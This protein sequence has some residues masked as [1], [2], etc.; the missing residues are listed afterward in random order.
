MGR[1]KRMT[2]ETL[3]RYTLFLQF[4][5]SGDDGEH[6]HGFPSIL[7]SFVS[8]FRHDLSFSLH[9]TLPATTIHHVTNYK[10]VLDENQYVTYN[11]T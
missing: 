8:V 1:D 2:Q 5:L 3:A 9:P 6:Q 11:A 7:G 10:L 4:A